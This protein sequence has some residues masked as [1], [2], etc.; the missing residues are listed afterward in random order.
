MI[1]RNRVSVLARSPR[2]LLGVD[3]DGTLAPIADRPEDARA[4]PR[5]LALLAQAAALPQTAV[6]VVSGRGL[7]DLHERIDAAAGLWLVGAHGAEIDG[8]HFSKRADDVALVLEAIAE[9][10]RRAAP[11]S[12]GFVHERK[13]VSIAVHYRQVGDATAALAVDTIVETI[14]NPAGLHVRHGKRVLELMAVDADKG[15]AVQRLRSAIG[16]STVVFLGDDITD[17]DAFRALGPGDLGVKIGEPPTEADVWVP[18]LGDGHRLIEQLVE[19]RR[20]W[21]LEARPTPIHHHAVLSDQRTI[22]VVR[23]DGR[24]VWLCL[25]RIDSP[26]VFAELLDGERAGFWSAGPAGEPP[27]PP[28]T[29]RYLGD[30]FTLETSWPS[31][32]VT[33]YLDGSGGR[34]FQ[35]AGRSDLVRVLEGH[36][37]ARV[38]FC[39]RLDFGRAKTKLVLEPGGVIVEGGADPLVL[40]APGVR[41]AIEDV[42]GVQRAVAEI[43]LVGSPVVLELRAGTRSLAPVRLAEP[44]RR[45][46]TERLWT[47]WA[48]SLQLPTLAPDACRRSALVLRSLVHGPTGA[49]LAAG[50]TSLP[51]T[52]GGARNWDYRF[53]WPRDAAIAGAALVRLGNTGIAMRFLDWLLGIVGRASGPERLRPI[54]TVTAEELGAEA[55]LSNLDGYR[56]SRPVRVGNAA[57]QQV[58]VD[59]FGPIVDLVFRLAEAGA[60]VSPDHWRLV[61]A[62]VLAV[63]RSWRDP[64]HGIW[65]VRTE[66][67]HHVHSKTMCWLAL[68]RAVKLADQF[69]GVRREA[70]ESLRDQV[71]QD[72]LEHGF[73]AE[74]GGF[75]AAYDLREPDAAALTVG[76][77]G[78]IGPDDPRFEGTVNLVQRRLLRGGTL[79][80]YAYPDELPGPEGGFHLCTGWLVESLALIGRRAEAEA[81][82][83]RLAAAVGPTGLMSEQWCPDE[84]TGLGN[85]AQAYSHA[86][87]IAGA[88]ALSR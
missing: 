82:F 80:R 37:S 52:A 15:R 75:V 66:K 30:T 85:L 22:A 74:L 31:L 68:D 21:L 50:T 26:S 29:Q 49:I 71:K 8:P 3:F 25:P 43:E 7:A 81:L 10:L 73:D 17:E 28:L 32:R 40:H 11:E 44:Q 19:T 48:A 65:E 33:D 61:E 72:V 78:L 60:A 39:P 56:H 62:M 4:D 6:A 64:D 51:E 20:R 55:E 36:G 58:Q 34:P 70:W 67:R 5:V 1:L 35:R 54:Y 69:V 14:A 41:W 84:Q 59:V 79:V 13:P 77:S 53:C 57:A 27:S 46:Q 38:A 47:S 63:E 45:A 76:L 18:T 86:A 24:I 23:P 9:P 12:E 87:L 42:G 83:A 16:A 88:V 2:L